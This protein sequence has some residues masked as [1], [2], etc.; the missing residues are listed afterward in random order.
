MNKKI[1][2]P[3]IDPKWAS[4]P[5]FSLIFDN[6]DTENFKKIYNN[7]LQQI[8]CQIK[9][10]TKLL[11]LYKTFADTLRDIGIE[12]LFK[13]YSFC[14]LPPYSYHVTVWDG[15]NRSNVVKA[16]NISWKKQAK[17]FLKKL[18]ESLFKGHKLLMMP[19]TTEPLSIAMN[20]PITYKFKKLTTFKGNKVLAARIIPDNNSEALNKY[21]KTQRSN[22]KKE[23]KKHYEVNTSP[24]PFSPHVSLGYFADEEHGKLAQSQKGIWT[25][26]FAK[27]SLNKTIIFNSISLYG[28]T[29]MATFYKVV[30]I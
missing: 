27:N 6:P 7:K 26:L 30:V 10:D 18:P 24:Y 19:N 25:K 28:F 23:F 29:D 15:L 22:I 17:T 5:G 9:K 21:V 12:Y 13:Q 14:L 11:Q 2:L 8:Y 3:G 20:S 1:L 4:Y 16:P